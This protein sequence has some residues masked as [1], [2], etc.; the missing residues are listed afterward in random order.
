[1]II[2]AA[3]EG[4]ALGMGRVDDGVMRPEVVYERA[5]VETLAAIGQPE[6]QERPS[7]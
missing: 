4:D 5:A 2:R 3:R 1:M 7:A 6:S